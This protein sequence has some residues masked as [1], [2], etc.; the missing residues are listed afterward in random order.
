MP[1]GGRNATAEE[2]FPALVIQHGLPRGLGLKPIGF[3]FIRIAHHSNPRNLSRT[4]LEIGVIPIGGGSRRPHKNNNPSRAIFQARP[5]RNPL[6]KP[7]PPTPTFR[8][9]YVPHG[10]E[11]PGAGGPAP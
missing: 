6:P 9:A 5:Q 11:A 8:G 3:H 7:G 1:A 4:A 2:R 10:R